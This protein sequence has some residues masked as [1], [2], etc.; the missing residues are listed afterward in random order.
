M[1]W[2]LLVATAAFWP[3]QQA[4]A[5]D[6]GAD[7]LISVKDQQ[8]A[9]VEKGAVVARYKVSTSKFGIG[10]DLGSYKTP[11]G[12]MFVCNKIGE[13]LPAGAVIK[14]RSFTGEVLKPN[15][16]GRDPIV[17]RVIWLRG[18]EPQNKHAYDRCIYI[19]GTAEEKHVGKPVSFGCVRMRSKDVIALYEAVRIGTRVTI[20]DEPLK[21]IVAEEEHGIASAP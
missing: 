5:I 6:F 10:D 20:S 7:I 8:M 3:V 12:A 21:R 14:G 1:G 16:P 19:H 17:S 9:V 13:N 4:L 2:G 15:A 11:L 18:I